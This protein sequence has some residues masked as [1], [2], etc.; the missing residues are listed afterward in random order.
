MNQANLSLCDNNVAARV[1]RAVRKKAFSWFGKKN[2]NKPPSPSPKKNER[3]K[4]T[5][6][7]TQTK[8]TK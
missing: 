4:Q 1:V 5:K 7:P 2:K 3:K 6:T 8:P